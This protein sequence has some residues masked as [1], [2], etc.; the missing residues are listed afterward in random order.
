MVTSEGMKD[1]VQ[2]KHEN[3]KEILSIKREMDTIQYGRK[4][5]YTTFLYKLKQ[6]YL[7]EQDKKFVG[8]MKLAHKLRKAI[9]R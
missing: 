5:E 3:A 6:K 9:S 2:V 1:V 4:T 8:R 7:N